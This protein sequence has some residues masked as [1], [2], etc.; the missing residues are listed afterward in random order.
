[1]PHERDLRLALVRAT[2]GIL[3]VLFAACISAAPTKEY[4][5]NR[6]LTATAGSSMLAWTASNGVTK[7]FI[8]AGHE[9]P[10]VKIYYR[11]YRNGIPHDVVRKELVFSVAENYSADQ[12]IHALTLLMYESLEIRILSLEDQSVTYQIVR[13]HSD[14]L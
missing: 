10:L 5:L 3:L 4:D 13:E 7:E 9:G 14:A 11:E 1:M 8:F 2:F 6:R 12:E